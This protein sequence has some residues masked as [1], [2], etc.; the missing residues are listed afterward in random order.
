[1]TRLPRTAMLIATEDRSTLDEISCVLNSYCGSV[2]EVEG[3]KEVVD[4]GVCLYTIVIAIISPGPKPRLT[5]LDGGR[6]QR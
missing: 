1:M 4:G 2:I 6:I 3:P 5:V